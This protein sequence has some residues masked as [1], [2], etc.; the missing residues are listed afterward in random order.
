MRYFSL[1]NNSGETLDI[2]TKT[3]FFNEIAGLGFEE[4]TSFRHVGET[5]WLNTA[6]YRQKPIAG[7]LTFTDFENAEPYVEFRK[8]YKFITKAPL[9]LV[10]FPDGLS[11]KEYRRKVRVTKLEKSE[12]NTYGVFDESVEFMPY[13]PWYELVT[14]ENTSG[15]IE[16]QGHW[17][18]G[19]GSSNPPVIFAPTPA[20]STPPRFGAEERRWVS[21][22]VTASSNSPSRFII[23]GP[24]NNPIWSQYV[25]GSLVATGG[26]SESV[27]VGENEA[28]V[29]DNV[30]EI[31]QIKVYS[32]YTVEEGRRELGEP[33]RDLYQKR[34]FNVPCFIT[35]RP[36]VNR[37]A[38]ATASS[39]QVSM[40]L[41]GYIYN[42]VV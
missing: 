42:A 35:L 25:D 12:L 15:E 24:I 8:F 36:G 27:S 13:T 31:S 29:I 3:I 28:L 21:L 6:S 18:W 11:G 22:D 14:C 26:F 17:I 41:E 9:Q 7:K 39:G 34:D 10:Y 16:Y 33:L 32:Y 30:D 2:T 19:D 23:Y 20:G 1:I 37:I 4:E 40:R 38:I 5:W